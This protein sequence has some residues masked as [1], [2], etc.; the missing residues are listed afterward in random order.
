MNKQMATMPRNFRQSEGVAPLLLGTYE[1][2]KPKEYD[3]TN[4]DAVLSCY[5]VI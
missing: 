1:S 3:K 5:Q 4:A 2:S